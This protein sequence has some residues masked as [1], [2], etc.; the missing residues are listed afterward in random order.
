MLQKEPNCCQ[1]LCPSL[2]HPSACG[3][4]NKPFSGLVG[5]WLECASASG[6]ICP[7]FL[8]VALQLHVLLTRD[9]PLGPILRNGWSFLLTRDQPLGPILHPRPWLEF[10]KNGCNVCRLQNAHFQ[11]RECGHKRGPDAKMDAKAI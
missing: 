5:E 2:Q 11:C 7:R 8:S 3:H 9:Q 4:A 6:W 10:K 1:Y